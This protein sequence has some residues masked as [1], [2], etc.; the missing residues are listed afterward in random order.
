MI[1]T[2][3]AILHLCRSGS[4][5]ALE[6]HRIEDG[7]RRL[8]ETSTTGQ[9]VVTVAQHAASF[10]ARLTDGTRRTYRAPILRLVFGAEFVGRRGAKGKYDLDEAKRVLDAGDEFEFP[11][12]A[13]GSLPVC[14]VKVLDLSAVVAGIRRLAPPCSTN[15]AE[16]HFVRATRAFFEDALLH[17][18][19]YENPARRIPIPKRNGPGRMELDDAQICEIRT[20]VCAHHHDP[21]LALL[22]IDTHEETAAR[23]SGIIG[24]N[25]RDIDLDTR[26]IRLFEKGKPREQPASAELLQRIVALASDRGSVRPDD[27]AFVQEKS[28]TR[29]TGRVYDGVFSRV[30]NKLPWAKRRKV[31]SHTLRHTTLLTVRR[32]KGENV[33]N[34]FAGHAPANVTE[35][36][37]KASHKEVVAAHARIFVT[38]EDPL[39][40]H[41]RF[42]PEP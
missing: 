10:L 42:A 35:I 30:G 5:S 16:E 28:R 2:A 3:E 17:D 6:L 12:G 33:A 39:S 1:D 19:C 23:R 15:S 13:L 36:Y 41:G 31:G 18:L 32:A 25:L 26:T 38:H 8:R 22:L 9:A 29:I 14:R 7:V 21:A 24:L 11:D 4:L 20:V 40:R 37:T 34:R 27:P